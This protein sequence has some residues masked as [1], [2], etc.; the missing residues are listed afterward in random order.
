VN[1]PK[2]EILELQTAVENCRKEAGRIHVAESKEQRN[3]CKC[4][5]RLEVLA[6]LK[7][8]LLGEISQFTDYSSYHVLIVD[9]DKLMREITSRMLKKNGFCHIDEAD[10]GHNAI[11]KIKA[12]KIPYSKQTPYD[13]VLCDLNMPT[14]SGLDLLKLVRKEN[15]F[16]KMPFIMITGTRDKENL[17]EVIKLGVRDFLTKPVNEEDLLEKIN[18]II[19]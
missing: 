13:F 19:L 6:S 7:N 17:L 8:K 3:R 9:D 11:V 10:D 18:S 2:K 4:T 15:P 16:S 1:F 5:E 12:K 14:I